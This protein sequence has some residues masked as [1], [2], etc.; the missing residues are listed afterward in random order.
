MM[1]FLSILVFV[2]GFAGAGDPA[3][4][5]VA[6]TLKGHKHTI[7]CLAFS[8]DGKTLASG[9]KDGTVILW[10][11]QTGKARATLAGHEDMVIRVAFSPDGKTLASCGVD[12]TARLWA[13]QDAK[14]IKRFNGHTAEVNC[15]AFSSDG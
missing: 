14:E 7:T 6:A 8:S 5:Q 15:V 3:P 11:V 2:S 13:W 9:S 1:Q 10:D 4:E 12:K